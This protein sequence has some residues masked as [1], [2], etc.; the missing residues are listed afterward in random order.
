MPGFDFAP[1]T[2][3]YFTGEQTDRIRRVHIGIAGAG[4]LGSNCAAHLV[5]S[6]FEK[7]TVADFDTV[8]RTNLN[9][10]FYFADQVGRPK[11]ECLKENLRRIN[12]AVSVNACR[13]RLTVDSMRSL[14]EP[15]GVVVEAFDGATDKASLV[16]TFA[17]TGKLVVSASGLAGIGNSDRIRTRAL[18]DRVFVVGDE[19]S[20][21]D[22]GVRPHAPRVAV[23]AAKMADIVLEWVLSRQ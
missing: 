21:V 23:A 19:T 9:R 5:R 14:F 18:G 15:C 1:V 7:F 10:Q 13:V 3:A 8:E 12:P 20:S 2:D 17:P 11:V 6:G 22:D 16:S 4:G